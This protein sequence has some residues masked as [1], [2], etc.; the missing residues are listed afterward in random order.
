MHFEWQDQYNQPLQQLNVANRKKDV[1]IS[2][3]DPTA[4]I[5]DASQIYYK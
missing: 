5:G 3:P 4:E 2:F 1:V